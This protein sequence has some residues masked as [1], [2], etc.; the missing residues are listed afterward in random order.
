MGR[1]WQGS[2][3]LQNPGQLSKRTPQRLDPSGGLGRR[4]AFLMSISVFL[5]LFCSVLI[6][7]S[8]GFIYAAEFL[9]HDLYHLRVST[10]S[11]RSFPWG[12]ALMLIKILLPECQGK[13][14]PPLF[15]NRDPGLGERLITQRLR[16]CMHDESV[17][18]PVD[19]LWVAMGLW[20]AH[21]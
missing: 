15:S 18:G 5:S 16:G 6:Y 13:D 19:R 7:V 3:F 10:D 4:F 21:T 11:L 12:A 8:Q 2:A 14:F 17:K 20:R 1:R 9:S